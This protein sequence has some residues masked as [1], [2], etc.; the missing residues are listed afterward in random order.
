MSKREKK[1]EDGR[2]GRGKAAYG[3]GGKEGEKEGEHPST[4]LGGEQPTHRKGGRN[5]I[6]V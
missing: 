1:R 5:K 6:T 3:G 2:G 4:G